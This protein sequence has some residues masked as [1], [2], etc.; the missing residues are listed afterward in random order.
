MKPLK[1]MDAW[2]DNGKAVMEPARELSELAKSALTRVTEQQVAVTKEYFT[3]GTQSVQKMG[4]IRD[5]RALV[6]QQVTL[7]KELGDKVLGSAEA[8]AKLAADLQGQF[9]N[10][11]EKTTGAVVAKAESV[12]VKAA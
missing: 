1:L 11:A 9:A 6:N 4:A 12:V 3:F 7:T 5:P 8:Y 10:W 2:I